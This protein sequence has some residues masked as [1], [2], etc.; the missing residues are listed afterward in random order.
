MTPQQ[1]IDF[2]NDIAA[3]FNAGKIPYPIHLS[4][5]GN[6]DWLI[7]FFKQINPQDW[8]FSTWRS[9]YHALLKNMSPEK[10]KAKIMAGE[11]MHIMDKELNFFS[12]SIVGGIP[13]CHVCSRQDS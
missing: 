11:S 1:L 12:S 6:E 7:D 4:G 13:F 10:L 8:V 5:T 3:E 9:H 2:E